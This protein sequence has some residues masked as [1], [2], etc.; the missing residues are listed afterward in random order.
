MQDPALCRLG[1][2]ERLLDPIAEFLLAPGQDRDP[3]LARCPVAGR[4]VEQCLDELVAGQLLGDHI[5]GMV[6][7]GEILDGLEA[8]GGSSC[9]AVEKPDFLE[10]EAQ[11]GGEFWHGRLRLRAARRTVTLPP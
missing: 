11:I 2:D 10:Y 8:A 6:V 4:H 1:I 5:R 3:P 9:E 7:R